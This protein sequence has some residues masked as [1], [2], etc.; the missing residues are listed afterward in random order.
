MK[1]T[2]F[3][4]PETDPEAEKAK[5]KVS[6]LEPE[7]NSLTRQ[8][9]AKK[10]AADPGYIASFFKKKPSSSS[11]DK[12]KSKNNKEDSSKKEDSSNDD[13]N[14]SSETTTKS[15]PWDKEQNLLDKL[16]ETRDEAQKIVDTPPRVFNLSKSYYSMRLNSHRNAVMSKKVDQMLQQPSAFPKVPTHLP[17]SQSSSAGVSDTSIDK[18]SGD[19]SI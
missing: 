18:P 10:K 12:D 13:N 5:I 14:K 6:Q 11:N 9:Q 19:D 16:I 8:I 3:A 1:D 7:I 15:E 2:G 17:G 4:T